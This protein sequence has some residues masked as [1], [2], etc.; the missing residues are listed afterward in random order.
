MSPR[1]GSDPLSSTRQGGT[2]HWR[3][4]GGR[5]VWGP[6][7][8]QGAGRQ[9][10]DDARGPGHEGDGD[11]VQVQDDALVP[12]TPCIKNDPVTSDLQSPGTKWFAYHCAEPSLGTPWIKNDPVTSDLQSP[13]TKRFA[14][15]CAKPS[16][17]RG[18]CQKLSQFELKE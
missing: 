11:Q 2:W 5:D 17:L 12:G 4:E 8:Y 16:V 9:V 1:C 15:H 18:Q 6:W 13:G 7:K 10:Q 3:H 14:Y